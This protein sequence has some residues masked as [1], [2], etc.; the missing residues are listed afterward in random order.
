MAALTSS[1]D[2]FLPTFTTRSTTDT[3]GAGTLSAMP[4]IQDHLVACVGVG[5]GH[6]AI[7][8][9]EA[10]VQDLA[11]GGHAICSARSIG[12]DGVLLGI[13]VAFVD[14]DHVGWTVLPPC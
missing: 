12:N 7:L 14:A 3:F 10:L 2:V 13:I 1:L 6:E 11:H 5:G 8:D 9:S 4:P